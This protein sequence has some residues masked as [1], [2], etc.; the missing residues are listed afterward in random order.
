MCWAGVAA[1]QVDVAVTY[2]RLDDRKPPTLS[3]I[4]PDPADL[5][6]AGAQVGLADNATTGQFLNHTY[7]L[8]EVVAATPADLLAASAG[9]SGLVVVQAPAATVLAIADALPGALVF[10]AAAADDSLRGTDCR[11]NLL[12]TAPSYAMRADALAQFLV[13]KRWTDVALVTG[14]APADLG[15]ADA[16]RGSAEKFGLRLRGDAPWGFTGDIRRT[17]GDE[18]PSFTQKLGDFDMLLVADE[19]H[20]FGRYLNYNTWEPR[21]VGGSEGLTPV[22]WSPVVEQWGAQQLQSRFRDAAGRGMRPVDYSAWAALRAIGEAVTRTGSNDPKILRSY[23]LGPEFTLAGF[24]GRALS[25]RAWNGQLR[26]P[27]PLVDA[28]A[29]VATAPLEGFLHPITELDTLGGD[30]PESTCT[31]FGE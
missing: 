14:P 8:T 18:V 6:I 19:I 9:A 26:Q 10:N 16:L 31:A 1:A 30:R 12:H 20:D 4:D 2:L 24:K 13:T 27:I 28:R 17:T 5:G 15:F 11:A 23:L 3:D 25:F 29:V 22:A 7:G 21:P